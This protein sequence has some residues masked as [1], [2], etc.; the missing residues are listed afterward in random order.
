MD[1]WLLTDDL[2]TVS[3]KQWMA[4]VESAE[5][6]LN[7]LPQEQVLPVRYEH[8]VE[9]PA[10]QLRRI[11]AWL[12]VE[13]NDGAIATAVAGVSNGSV[14]RGRSALSPKELSDIQS[15]LSQTLALH[16]ED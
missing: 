9:K 6:A 11:A 10:A 5:A 1:A 16:A 7:L 13:T 3:A 15:I 12:D 14:G 4:C 2:L 8:F